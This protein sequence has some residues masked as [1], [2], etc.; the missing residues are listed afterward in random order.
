MKTDKNNSKHI[1]FTTVEY[2]LILCMF[3]PFVYSH[4]YLR[5][6]GIRFKYDVVLMI[7]TVLICLFLIWVTGKMLDISAFT[8]KNILKPNWVNYLFMFVRT[9]ILSYVNTTSDYTAMYA[10]LGTI[11]KNQAVQKIY[12]LWIMA[13]AVIFISAFFEESYNKKRLADIQPFPNTY[14]IKSGF[15]P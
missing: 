7:S 10:R 2:L 13:V 12:F 4:I 3:V 1:I 6:N 14:K 15:T 9:F 5:K 11:D 8:R